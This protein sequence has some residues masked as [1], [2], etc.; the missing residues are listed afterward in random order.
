MGSSLDSCSLFVIMLSPF[1]PI[2]E[3]DITLWIIGYLAV[4]PSAYEL[5]LFVM[6]YLMGR[7]LS[8]DH[9]KSLEI[10]AMMKINQDKL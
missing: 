6:G 5:E 3:V 7:I 9:Y 4:E 2:G 1:V 10:A 8:P